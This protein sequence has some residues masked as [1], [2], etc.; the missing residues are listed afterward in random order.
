MRQASSSFDFLLVTVVG[1]LLVIE[2]VGS[3]AVA[4]VGVPNPLHQELAAAHPVQVE[5]GAGMR[6]DQQL[7]GVGSATA[8]SIDALAEIGDLGGEAGVLPGVPRVDE[9]VG[10]HLRQLVRHHA[11][12]TVDADVA[13][14]RAL[15]GAETDSEGRHGEGVGADARAL[16]GG[17][18]HPGVGEG[19]A[20]DGRESEVV[21]ATGLH[22]EV[23]DGDVGRGEDEVEATAGIDRDGAAGGG[24]GVADDG[25]DGEAGEGAAAGVV[26]VG[27]LRAEEHDGGDIGA[28]LVG[29]EAD[30]A[31]PG[32]DGRVRGGRGGDG[33][34]KGTEDVLLSRCPSTVPDGMDGDVG[35]EHGAHVVPKLH[36][37]RRPL[38]LLRHPEAPGVYTP[39]AATASVHGGGGIDGASANEV[40]RPWPPRH[41]SEWRSDRQSREREE[42]QAGARHGHCSRRD[43]T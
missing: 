24:H 36:E 10:G 34:E 15:R 42:Q 2:C 5:G 32:G 37:L 13:V 39:T 18:A 19:V 11:D 23:L 6:V 8:G 33:A 31:P 1:R 16:G 21:E 4:Q 25:L 43:Y 17:V 14:G 40:V 9:R 38:V 30:G 28:G 3:A 35:R 29:V 27:P 12:H 41:N 20:D 26:A 22:A 7:A